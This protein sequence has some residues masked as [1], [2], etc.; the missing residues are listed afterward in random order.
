VALENIA[1]PAPTG[2]ARE[3]FAFFEAYS[4]NFRHLRGPVTRKGCVG[5]LPDVRVA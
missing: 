3:D 1:D 4:N 5:A 2:V